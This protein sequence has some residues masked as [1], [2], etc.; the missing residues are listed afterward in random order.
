MLSKINVPF[1][2]GSQGALVGELGEGKAIGFEME[3]YYSGVSKA[4]SL[5]AKEHL[6]ETIE[7]KSDFLT[8][9]S[10]LQEHPLFLRV[11][12]DG[13]NIEFCTEPMTLE[14][15]YKIQPFMDHLFLQFKVFQFLCM[16]YSNVDINLDVD[17]FSEQDWLNLFRFCIKNPKFLVF[18][19]GR[20][21]EAQNKADMRYLLLHYQSKW[22]GGFFS[23]RMAAREMHNFARAVT[24]KKYESFANVHCRLNRVEIKWFGNAFSYATIISYVEMLISIVNFKRE[25]KSF[26]VDDYYTFLQQNALEYNYFFKRVKQEPFGY[27][28]LPGISDKL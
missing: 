13:G 22:G 28:N 18:F 3:F 15:M 25:S 10:K 23:R 24:E 21:Q 12:L 2:K 9:L 5:W 1:K 26:K 8:Y 20:V 19:S 16:P 6:G 4:F 17:F 11:Y 14:V 7:D 27:L